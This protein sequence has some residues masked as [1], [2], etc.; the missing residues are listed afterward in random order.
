M[1]AKDAGNFGEKVKPLETQE[2]VSQA[3]DRL[4]PICRSI[5]GQGYRD[6]LEILKEYIP[7]E[8][9]VFYSGER[10]LNW[11]VPQEWV[12]R[13]AWIQDEE[14]N[15]IIDF[16]ENNLHVL[17][18]SEPVDAKM[19]LEELKK[20]IYT[21][22][23][24]DAVPYVF[25]Y[26]KRR[27]GFCMSQNQLDGLADGIYHVYIDSE[28]ISGRLIIGET[29]LPGQSGKEIL[30]SS[31]LCHPS[32]ANNE[33]SGTLVL[34]MLYQRIRRWKNRKYT[35]RFLVNPETIGGI[36]YLS[37]HGERLKK[38]MFAGMV[39]TCL[40]GEEEK[41]RYKSSR[42]GQAPFDLLAAA[43]VNTFRIEPFTPVSGSDERQY[44]SPGFNLPMGQI[45]RKVYKEYKEYHTSADTK[46]LMGIHNIMES[47][48]K[49]EA[50]LIQ[51][52]KEIYYRNLYP[53]GE[54][55]LGDYDLYPSVNSG[56]SRTTGPG[57]LVNQEWFIQTVM[58]ILNY[59]DGTHPLS[60]I[61]SRLGM[62]YENV[63]Q[64]GRVLEDRG[65]VRPE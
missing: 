23:L 61:A 31:Y 1:D 28:F 62:S 58:M 5:L 10:V 60:Y 41:L 25:S 52:E 14:G 46:E 42:Q 59:S 7:M 64:V 55:K 33:L 18:Y 44:C 49:I 15:V 43:N 51:N 35:Y 22:P 32:M 11:T 19:E 12:I 9:E 16:K 56:G 54:V 13:E 40:G 30:F 36:S 27:W 48:D 50:F 29:V 65:L 38:D 39:L 53:Y 3:F 4:F 8:E 63:K 20:H 6:S 34:A 45:A 37:R 17:N 57:D 47:C 2:E 26:Y 24:R 21:S